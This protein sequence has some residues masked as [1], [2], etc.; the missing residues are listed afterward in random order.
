M[1][2]QGKIALRKSP[3]GPPILFVPKPDGRLRLVVD[4]RGLNKLRFTT[5]ILFS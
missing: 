5:N 2:K 4:Y 3:A 1:L